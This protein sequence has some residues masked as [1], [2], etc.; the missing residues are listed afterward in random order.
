MEMAVTKAGEFHL[1]RGSLST[2]EPLGQL[3]A[4]YVQ[5]FGRDEAVLC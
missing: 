4:W 3:R 2:L 5:S 1:L